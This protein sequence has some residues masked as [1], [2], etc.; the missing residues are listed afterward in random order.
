MRTALVTVLALWGGLSA[1]VY[2]GMLLFARTHRHTVSWRRYFTV[3]LPGAMALPIWA[4]IVGFA[5]GVVLYGI[6]G[7]VLL[8]V[9]GAGAV[10]GYRSGAEQAVDGERST[11]R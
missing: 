8:A 7:L 6:L 2:V 4:T 9:V 10:W 5:N 11:R 1:L 3:C